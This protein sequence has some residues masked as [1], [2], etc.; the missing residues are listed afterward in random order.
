MKGVCDTKGQTIGFLSFD[1]DD[2]SYAQMLNIQKFMNMT[3][4]NSKIDDMSVLRLKYD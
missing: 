2:E 1:D 3:T 4:K